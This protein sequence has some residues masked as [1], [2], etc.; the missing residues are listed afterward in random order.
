LTS[1]WPSGI[2]RQMVIG[3]R[4]QKILGAV[5]RDY[6]E[7]V[8]PVG[9]EELAARYASWGVKSATI[10][11]ELAELADLGLLRQPHTSAGRI[12]SDQGYRFYVDHL[13]SAGDPEQFADAATSRLNTTLELES[14]L[15]HTC[16]LL[17]R[18]TSYTSV[19]T[20]P[21]PADTELTG[22][23][24]TPAG[25]HR[26]LVAML[27][28][29]GQVQNRILSLADDIT[30]ADL[31]SLGNAINTCLSGRSI[32]A[33]N[34]G[35]PEAIQSSVPPGFGAS[36]RSLYSAIAQVVRD[37]IRDVGDEDHVFLEGATEI[38]KQ[39]EF[40]DASKSDIV[41]ET[42]HRGAAMFQMVARSRTHVTVVIGAENR[43]AAMHEC[44]VVTAPYYV[45]ARLRGTIGVVGPTRMH[46]DRAVP[47]VNFFAST[48]SSTLTHLSA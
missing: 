22:V 11:N 5:V 14:L 20:P 7:T 6:I 8:R 32:E 31:T 41:L 48:L 13:M 18:M 46:Y 43:I 10:R 35:R 47:A 45:G 16:A 26:L 2:L 3:D 34:A 4:K 33:I 28:S 23:F 29:T 37:A 42:L 24:L 17:T 15:R 38:F 36:L 27:L 19:A 40:R 39:P 25:D 9:S 21:R 12:P 44:S 30:G 1:V